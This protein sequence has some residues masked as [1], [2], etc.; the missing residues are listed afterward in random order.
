M[1]D[2][3]DTLGGASK[4]LGDFLGGVGEAGGKALGNF[5]DE[6]KGGFP[7]VQ[8]GLKD[9]LGGSFMSSLFPDISTNDID[10]KIDEILRKIGL[11]KNSKLDK[12]PGIV[13]PGLGDK[14]DGSGALD[15]LRDAAAD[16]KEVMDTL[17][18]SIDKAKDKLRELGDMAIAG[19]HAFDDKAF[20]FKQQMNKLELRITELKVSNAPKKL[21]EALN[22]QKE[23]LQLRATKV[24]LTRSVR[25]APQGHR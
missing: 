4:G 2:L 1:K 19:E 10:K 5:V 12:G 9:L 11:S 25:S 24:D 20:A 16:A 7:T 21:I 3:L 17:K 8:K 18:D 23:Q 15:T 13:I 14:M 6:F 22:K